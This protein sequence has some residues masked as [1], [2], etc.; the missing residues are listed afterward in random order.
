MAINSSYKLSVIISDIRFWILAFLLLRLYGISDPPIEIAHS[1]RQVC[2]N[3]IARNFLEIDANIFFPRL[4]MA[5]EKSGITGTEFPLLNYLIYLV[6]KLFGYAHWYGRLINLLVSSIGTYYFFR[7]ISKH[8]NSKLAFNATIM[9]LVSIWFSYSRKIMPDT[10]SVAIVIAGLYFGLE[11]MYRKATRWNLMLYT[12]LAASGILCKIPSIIILSP[13]MLLLFDA[14]ISI[15]RKVNITASSGMIMLLPG[16]WYFYWVPHL[17]EEFGYWHYYMGTSISQGLHELF[18]YKF[19]IAEKFFF[20]AMKFSGFSLFIFGLVRLYINKEKQLSAILIFSF[21]LFILFILIAGNNFPR[22]SYYIIPYVPFMVLAAAYG[23][24]TI[25][26]R[27]IQIFLLV[28]IVVEGI[29]NQ[30]HDF[31]LKQ[32]E[33]Y[34][35]KLE[36]IADRVSNPNDLIAINGNENPQELYFTHRKGWTI[37]NEKC[38][39]TLFLDIIKKKGCKYLFIN[40][41][42]SVNLHY[43]GEKVFEDNNYKVFSMQ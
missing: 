19:L 40:K 29:G 25:K 30:Q 33:T 24:N 4:D 14:N 6:S 2:G 11:Y 38:A 5:G 23:L 37:S 34:K 35:L 31:R 16:F 41:K 22:H 20:D 15:R 27:W 12:I 18:N 28:F 13:I 3:M 39:D 43:L 7:I 42:D 9:L 36:E 26:R 8:I 21:F 10:F 17:V 32:S 1:W